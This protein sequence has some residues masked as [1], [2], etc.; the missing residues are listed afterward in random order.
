MSD[1]R[2]RVK[3]FRRVR[4]AELRLNPRNWRTHPQSQRSALR[5]VLAEV[6]FA[7]AVLAYE[8]AEGL[9]LIDGHLRV[10]EMGEREVPVLVLDVTDAEADKLLLSLDPLAAL[11]GRDEAAL[12]TLLASVA[13]ADADFSAFLDDIKGAE[14]DDSPPA[15]RP[16]PDEF[17]AFDETIATDHECPKCGYRWSGGKVRSDCDLAD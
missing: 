10:D 11:A 2:D 8:T 16:P 5:G 7:D 9:T 17:K 13:P 14:P 1:I 12:E 3:E 15:D 6:G 4:A